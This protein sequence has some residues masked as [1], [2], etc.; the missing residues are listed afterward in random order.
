MSPD[1]GIAPMSDGL[2]LYE[3]DFV[4]RSAARSGVNLPLDWEHLAEEIDN[5]GRS[6]RAELRN[7]LATI[8]EHLLKLEVSRAVD[9]RAGWMETIQRER[10]EVEAPLDENQ[11]L[12]TMLTESLA[13]A[14][15]KS[16]KLAEFGLARH[17]K[18]N[19]TAERE[20]EETR[21]AD[22]EVLGPWL[23]EAWPEPR[24]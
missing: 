9:P 10:V 23:P 16:R 24:M 5:L 14:D 18:W 6:L 22:A 13:S 17:S 7:R 11:S 8:I 15:R 12:R 3:R 2:N 19:P 21:F 20:L 1:A 4:R